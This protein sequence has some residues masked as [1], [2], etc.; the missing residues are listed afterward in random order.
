M[1]QR[2]EKNNFLGIDDSL[3]DEVPEENDSTEEVADICKLTKA[4]EIN[5]LEIEL[6]YETIKEFEAEQCSL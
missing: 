4:K 5:G 6:I 3:T 1:I 2:K